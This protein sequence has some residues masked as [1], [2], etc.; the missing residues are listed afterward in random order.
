MYRCR[1]EQDKKGECIKLDGKEKFQYP[2]PVSLSNIHIQSQY[3]STITA[4]VCL[5]TREGSTDVLL[6]DYYNVIISSHTA[7]WPPTAPIN[8]SFHEYSA[9]SI[10]GHPTS[11]VGL[12]SSTALQY[13]Y[14][15]TAL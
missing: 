9:T 12:Y 13:V 11:G 6:L 5:R 15:S 3:Q 4:V 8:T 2:Y 1:K 10:A 7:T 14:S